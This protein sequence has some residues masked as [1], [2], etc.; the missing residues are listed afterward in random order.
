MTVTTLPAA[1]TK[2][3]ERK[4]DLILRAASD[5]INESGMRGMALADVAE[6]VRLSTTSVTYYFRKK[7]QLAAACFGLALARLEE[8]VAL[9]EAEPGPR[10]RTARLVQLYFEATTAAH[11][12]R[13]AAVARLSEIRALDDPLREETLE[14]YRVIVRRV[15]AML[16]DGSGDASREIRTARA[17]TLLEMLFWLDGWIGRYAPEDHPRVRRRFI[18]IL[19]VGLAPKGWRW[20]PQA[21]MLSLPDEPG[22]AITAGAARQD[23]LMAATRLINERGYRGASV[24]RIASEL[25]VTKGSFYHHLDAKDDLVLACFQRSLQTIFQ[26]QLRS[27]GLGGDHL[28]NLASCIA[29]LLEFQF[30]DEGPLL[31]TTALQALPPELRERM[32]D[33]SNRVAARFADMMIDAIGE[34]AMR[35]VDPLIASQML[36]AA[37]NGAYEQRAWADR[38]PSLEEAIDIYASILFSGVFEPRR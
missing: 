24:E 14:R 16:D 25:N 13:Q 32:V 9:A 22:A 11:Q 19:E 37:I 28:Q 27:D 8:F 6:R 35:P 5:L 20:A 29:R 21:M 12:G 26:A 23:F 4:R 3:F 31:R 18:E 33:R 7:E 2:R 15:R 38:Q 1:S 30:S 10:E 36:M 34:G 17:N